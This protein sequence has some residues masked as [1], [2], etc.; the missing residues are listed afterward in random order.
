MQSLYDDSFYRLL[1][2][3]TAAI[4]S[5]ACHVL[6]DEELHRE[7]A[8]VLDALNHSCHCLIPMTTP[9]IATES[10][11]IHTGILSN[12]Q[13]A[14]I[15]Q[16]GIQSCSGNSGAIPPFWQTCGGCASAAAVAAPSVRGPPCSML[17]PVEHL[18]SMLSPR[19]L[20]RRQ[21]SLAD[22]S[23]GP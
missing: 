4:A 16:S 7:Y 19:A 13:S 21:V 11:G 1:P 6:S 9:Q 18:E 10:P 23:G 17:P 2:Q 14:G 20:A 12:P 15:Q 22:Q 8:V 3:T 5:A